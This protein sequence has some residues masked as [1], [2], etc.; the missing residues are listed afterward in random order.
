MSLDLQIQLQDAINGVAEQ[1]YNTLAQIPGIGKITDYLAAKA[2]LTA[3][4]T[5][6]GD[7]EI[8]KITLY[9][10][11]TVNDSVNAEYSEVPI[12]GRS[13][14]FVH[15]ASTGTNKISFSGMLVAGI[16]GLLGLLYTTTKLN[17]DQNL[18]KSWL[19]PAYEGSTVTPPPLL[20]LN[21]GNAYQ[22]VKGIIRS[23]EFTQERPWSIEHLPYIVRVSIDFEIL[24]SFPVDR[25][26]IKTGMRDSGG[27]VVRGKLGYFKKKAT[28]TWQQAKKIKLPDIG[29]GW[30][31]IK[32][33]VDFD[34]GKSTNETS[35]AP[36]NP[37]VRSIFPS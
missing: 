3:V 23:L 28:D 5:L 36:S 11:E 25:N 9:H 14:P 24:Y 12:R 37:G 4:D 15:Y 17:D 7:G 6:G 31:G 8:E 33:A 2:M 16:D 26:H 30:E 27:D 22:G 18:L 10:Y 32:D 34:F 13:Q 20:Q 21:M 19:Y 1:G 29:G 35:Q